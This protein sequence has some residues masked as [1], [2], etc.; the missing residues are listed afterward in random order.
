MLLSTPSKGFC[1][2]KVFLAIYFCRWQQVHLDWENVCRVLL[3][4]AT[5]TIYTVC[6]IHTYTRLTALCPGL[7]GWAG[8][9]KV[10]PTW[11][12]LKQ[13]TVSG[14]GISWAV[15]KS[16]PRSRQITMPALHHSVFYR[17]D[18]VW[19]KKPNCKQTILESCAGNG[20]MLM[21][22]RTDKNCN[23]SATTN[24][25]TQND[26]S[27]TTNTQQMAF[28]NIQSATCKVGG[29]VQW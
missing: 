22:W 11:I 27:S 17:L 5:Y 6:H 2:R 7:P 9:R 21:C 23:H 20:L 16:V 19:H 18:A 13:K 12:L 14:S 25:N 24:N 15:C 10:K 8:T 28:H 1:C 26:I 29:M 3:C 4:G